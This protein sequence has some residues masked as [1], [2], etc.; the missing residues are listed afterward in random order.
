VTD[1][2]FWSHIKKTDDMNRPRLQFSKIESTKEIGVKNAITWLNEQGLNSGG[3]IRNTLSNDE[4]IKLVKF[5][6]PNFKLV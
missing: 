2:F 5:L 4:I 3:C 6:Q 1:S